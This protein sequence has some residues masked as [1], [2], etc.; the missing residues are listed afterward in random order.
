MNGGAFMAK[1][2]KESKKNSNKNNPTQENEKQN[3]QDNKQFNIK[4]ILKYKKEKNYLK[5]NQVI[6]F[7]F[8]CK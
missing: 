6:L 4:Y 1:K 2:N 5:F 7:F 3:K 8:I